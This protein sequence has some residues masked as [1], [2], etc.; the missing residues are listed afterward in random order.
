MT[1]ASC[2]G[3]VVWMGPWSNLTHTECQQ[4]GAVNNQVDENTVPEVEDDCDE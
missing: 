2:G 4:C 3:S 1:C